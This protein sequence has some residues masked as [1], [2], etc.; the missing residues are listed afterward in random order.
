MFPMIC[1]PLYEK[2]IPILHQRQAFFYNDFY[3]QNIKVGILVHSQNLTLWLELPKFNF[4]SPLACVF[5]EL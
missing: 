4:Y 3:K 1:A 2:Y 5:C